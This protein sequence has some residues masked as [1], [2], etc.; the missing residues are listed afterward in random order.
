MSELDR[1]MV[2]AKAAAR[3]PVLPK[4]ERRFVFDS[5]DRESIQNIVDRQKAAL[6]A[7]LDCEVDIVD[8]S[9]DSIIIEFVPYKG[10]KFSVSKNIDKKN[11]EWRSFLLNQ[12]M[13]SLVLFV[14]AFELDPSLDGSCQLWLDDKP[15]YP[16]VTFSTNNP[17]QFCLPDPVFISGLSYVQARNNASVDM[18]PWK[19][20]RPKVLW[21]GVSTGNR[22]FKGASWKELPRCRMCLLVQQ[23]N[24]PDLFDIG[25][26][27]IV[28]IWDN[29]EVEEI[30]DSG[31]MAPE[32]RQSEF[33]KYQYA[34]DIDGN[35]NSWPGLF[36][37]LIY[38]NVVLKI[39]NW[40]GSRQW[41]YDRLIPWK[42][43]VPISYDMNE[44]LDVVEWLIRK[45]HVSRA[46]S[47]NAKA[48][49]GSMIWEN[50]IEI[51]AENI[52]G[53]MRGPERFIYQSA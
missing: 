23:Y 53:Y 21:R 29:K 35:V 15:R 46:I 51:A 12:W 49:A 2:R 19:S 32:C 48:L 10:L 6:F 7:T 11:L 42:N 33:I 52:I 38:G 13:S 44:L 37:K 4:I 47:E 40:D 24:R 5:I 36:H 50:E 45:P 8:T 34:I 1:V 26:S 17:S 25:I 22:P 20:R 3:W 28:Q 16:G 14:R 18:L 9:F 31:I 43:F 27:K 30:I 39:D 41:Y